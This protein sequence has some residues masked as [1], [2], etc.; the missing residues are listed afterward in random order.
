MNLIKRH[1]KISEPDQDANPDPALTTTRLLLEGRIMADSTVNP[2]SRPVKFIPPAIDLIGQRFGR[3]IVIARHKVPGE[4]GSWLCRCDCG[5]ETLVTRD[6]LIRRGDKRSCGC[7]TK[8]HGYFSTRF[9]PTHGAVKTP[10]YRTWSGMIQRCTN[11]ATTGYGRYGGRGIR[12]CDRW[13]ESFENF[14]ADMGE[15]PD[16]T[17]LDRINN[18]GN[19]EPMNCRWANSKQQ[20][21]NKRGVKPIELFGEKKSMGA[22]ARDPRC[23]VSYATAMARISRYGWDAERAITAPLLAQFSHPHS[24][25]GTSNA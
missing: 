1:A 4:R 12:V 19:Y 18:N 10:T 7:W 13:L 15:R 11:P 25:K 2:V 17:T 6:S 5:K 24:S 8:E 14:L 21:E 16:G 3:L 20:G 23:S 22:W 9:K